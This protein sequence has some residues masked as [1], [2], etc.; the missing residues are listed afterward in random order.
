MWNRYPGNNEWLHHD[1][2]CL[3]Y[4]NFIS[5]HWGAE[6][7]SEDGQK[8]MLTNFCSLKGFIVSR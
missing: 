6:A 8:G 3:V 1:M 2:F 4:V 5:L 7:S